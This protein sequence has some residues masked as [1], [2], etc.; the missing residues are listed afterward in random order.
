VSGAAERDA[1][2]YELLERIRWGGAGPSCPHCGSEECR[3]L[4]PRDGLTRPTRTGARTARRVWRCRAC[5][6][7]FSVLTGTVLAGSRVP[8]P[9]LVAALTDWAA[10]GRP[11]PR[12][13]AERHG[14]TPEAARHLLRRVGAA[15]DAAGDPDPFAAVFRGGD[16]T[17]LRWRTPARRR[18]RPQSGPSADHGAR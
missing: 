10:G 2:A 1:A 11:S 3:Y 13:L 4:A 7:Q 12:A 8:V 14:L 16:A 18:P 17:A 15:I 9:V 6:R 5:R